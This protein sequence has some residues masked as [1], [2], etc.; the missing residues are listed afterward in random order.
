MDISDY[1][2]LAGFVVA[3]I[4]FLVSFSSSFSDFA[5]APWINL[6]L[7]LSGLCF[8]LLGISLLF[9]F[10]FSPNR[11]YLWMLEIRPVIAFRT[12]LVIYK[13]APYFPLIVGLMAMIAAMR[14]ERKRTSLEKNKDNN[15]A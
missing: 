8:F 11:Y 1:I 3:C 15:S 6:L 12:P 2:A 9:F 7:F 10:H 14:Q 4:G 13:L 5:N